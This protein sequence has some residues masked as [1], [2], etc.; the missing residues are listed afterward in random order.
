MEIETAIKAAVVRNGMDVHMDKDLIECTYGMQARTCIFAAVCSGGGE[1]NAS[2]IVGSE[3]AGHETLPG[4]SLVGV[5]LWSL[6]LDS[7][8]G[9]VNLL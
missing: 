1:G 3:F 2:K 8:C 7:V 6:I 4:L 5:R 9:N